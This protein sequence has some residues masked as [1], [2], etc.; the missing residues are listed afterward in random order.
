M[1]LRV[2]TF[3]VIKRRFAREA[4]KVEHPPTNPSRYVHRDG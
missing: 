4:V 2:D 1:R 3:P